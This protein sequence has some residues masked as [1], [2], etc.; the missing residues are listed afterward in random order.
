MKRTSRIPGFY[1]EPVDTRR[2]LLAEATDL[3]LTEM[4]RAL[5]SGG[6]DVTTA[7]KTVENVLGTYALPFSLGL[8]VRI[9]DRDWLV[10]MVVEEPSVVAA[11]SNASKMIRDGG[12]FSADH[13]EPLMVAQVQLW[14]VSDPVTASVRVMAE[15]SALRAMADAAVP[16][17]VAR[18]GGARAIETRDLGDG[19]FVVHVVVDVRDAMGAN[20]V[21][22]VAEKLAPTIASLTGGTV[23]LRIL[24]NL[25]DLSLIHI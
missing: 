9:N 3:E 11:A 4:A 21:N 6:L 14:N 23:G 17:L 18:G 10:P 16:G 7:D 22:S 13:D 1:K 5:A 19:L 15:E 20:L 8:N 24:S 25:S 12:G 2:R